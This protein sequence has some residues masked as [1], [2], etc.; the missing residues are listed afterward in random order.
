MSCFHN[1]FKYYLNYHDFS[2]YILTANIV[3][4][5]YSTDFTGAIENTKS[6]LVLIWILNQFRDYL[7]KGCFI[8]MW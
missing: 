3:V 5:F 1:N 7:A 2:V 8:P 6:V 4:A